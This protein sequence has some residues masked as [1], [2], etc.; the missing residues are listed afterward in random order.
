MQLSRSI[1]NPS[2]C[3][4]ATS[5]QLPWPVTMAGCSKFAAALDNTSL[6]LWHQT[7]D[8]YIIIAGIYI[9]STRPAESWVR[10]LKPIATPMP[11][12]PCAESREVTALHHK[13]C[14]YTSVLELVMWLARFQASKLPSSPSP[15]CHAGTKTPVPLINRL[16]VLLTSFPPNFWSAPSART[17]ECNITTHNA[18]QRALFLGLP[19]PG[20]RK[21]ASRKENKRLPFPDFP[22]SGCAD[23]RDA[24]PG[25]RLLAAAK[26]TSCRASGCSLALDQGFV[27]GSLQRQQEKRNPSLGCNLPYRVT[28]LGSWAAKQTDLEMPIDDQDAVICKLEREFENPKFVLDLSQLVSLF[29]S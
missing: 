19:G 15:F 21:K 16:E 24:W 9:S 2:A 4:P 12:V 27:F 6:S 26:G 11:T 13:C 3:H 14:R 10:H 23:E 29:Q 5:C 7:F 28:G 18:Q 8:Q 22:K 20:V 17:L 1:C 25:R